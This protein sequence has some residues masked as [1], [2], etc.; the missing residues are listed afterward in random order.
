MLT[1][2]KIS[3]ARDHDAGPQI[4]MFVVYAYMQD[5]GDVSSATG[6]PHLLC[7]RSISF[8]VTTP[9]W[10]PREPVFPMALLCECFAI[11]CSGTSPGRWSC[12]R[13]TT[14]VGGNR[15][16]CRMF[17]RLDLNNSES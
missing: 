10:K 15:M 14:I 12:C 8:L 11:S 2:H 16:K 4:H 17:S 3:V 1:L 5:I 13:A 9:S 6:R 7:M